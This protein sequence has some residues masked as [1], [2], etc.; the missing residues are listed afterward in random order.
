ML[1]GSLLADLVSALASEVE[2]GWEA[3]SVWQ[4]DERIAPD[5]DED[6]SPNYLPL[7]FLGGL[8]IVILIG[9][10]RRRKD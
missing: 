10:A 8:L 9:A 1:T 3:A 5:G 2:V 7:I 4:V 6:R